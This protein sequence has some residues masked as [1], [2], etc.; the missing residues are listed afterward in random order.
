MELGERSHRFDVAL[1]GPHGACP[2]MYG[3]SGQRQRTFFRDCQ[4]SRNLSKSGL[5]INL[6]YLFIDLFLE[7]VIIL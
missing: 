5:F 3:L 7:Y 6:D 4:I 2:Q 1:L